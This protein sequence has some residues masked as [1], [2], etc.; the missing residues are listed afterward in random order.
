MLKLLHQCWNLT[1]AFGQNKSLGTL[2]RPW[3]KWM[4]WSCIFP[5]E[6]RGGIVPCHVGLPL[7]QYKR[8]KCTGTF[9]GWRPKSLVFLASFAGKQ[10]FDFCEGLTAR[11]CA[12]K[13]AIRLAQSPCN[14]TPYMN[15]FTTRVPSSFT[16]LLPG[17]QASLRMH[18]GC[19]Q[20][21]WSRF[22][23]KVLGSE[24]L[25]DISSSLGQHLKMKQIFALQTCELD[26]ALHRLRYHFTSMYA[27]YHY[28]QYANRP[29]FIQSI[30]TCTSEPGYPFVS[31]PPHRTWTRW[32]TV[33]A[34][35]GVRSSTLSLSYVQRRR[36][37]GSWMQLWYQQILTRLGPWGNW[38]KL[39]TCHY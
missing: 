35:M 17:N 30:I 34:T 21:S 26:S 16:A 8:S 29:S 39:Y 11:Q 31:S 9:C 4:F 15:Q 5:I 3:E 10:S 13:H 19:I 28:V 7:K 14:I 38:W 2:R 32:P 24:L 25:Q 33:L 37:R 23:S 12:R 6:K 20:D 1:C 18:L 27:I 36:G 22:C